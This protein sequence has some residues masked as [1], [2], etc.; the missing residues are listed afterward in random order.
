MVVKPMY[1]YKCT[2]CGMRMGCLQKSEAVYKRK[3]STNCL[4][5]MYIA[6]HD[7]LFEPMTFLYATD[8]KLRSSTLSVS[9]AEHFNSAI[10]VT[11]IHMS[12]YLSAVSAIRT[13]STIF[14]ISKFDV[15][16]ISGLFGHEVMYVCSFG[17]TFIGLEGKMKRM[18][19]KIF[20]VFLI[21]FS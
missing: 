2:K 5:C 12:S 9:L 11:S 6:H 14:T 18:I 1:K 4:L 10:C 16:L 19:K 7:A 15:K 20:K 3:H 8:N 13:S 17:V 21:F